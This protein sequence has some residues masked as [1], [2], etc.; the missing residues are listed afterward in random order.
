MSDEQPARR[1]HPERPN[2]PDREQVEETVEKAKEGAK[3]AL[4]WLGKRFNEAVEQAEKIEPL[5][6]KMDQVRDKL[7]E[8]AEQK[9][10]EQLDDIYVDAMRDIEAQVAECDERLGDLGDAKQTIN[11]NINALR[12]RGTA[13]DDPELL[14]YQEHLQAM[15]ARE[16]RL[17]VTKTAL[18]E[19]Q[20]RLERF[21]RAMLARLT[22]DPETLPELQSEAAQQAAAVRE[23]VAE[24]VRESA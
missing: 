4:G 12:L 6:Q 1:G 16:E 15:R 8:R 18:G 21:R 3:K 17:N 2:L 11:S 7:D 13:K 23:R 20:Q 24:I 19:E 22:A 5:R 10:E 14:E 9:R